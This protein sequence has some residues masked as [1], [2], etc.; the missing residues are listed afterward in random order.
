MRMSLKNKGALFGIKYCVI[1]TT[2]ILEV[3]DVYEKDHPELKKQKARIIQSAL[4]ENDSFGGRFERVWNR[5]HRTYHQ[6]TTIEDKV[7]EFEVIEYIF[8]GAMQEK[9]V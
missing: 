5:S 2:N 3:I 4:K 6:N 7:E 1:A 8:D 9:T